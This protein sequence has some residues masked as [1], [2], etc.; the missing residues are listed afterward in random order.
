MN[1]ICI[2]GRLT[3]DPVLRYT[4]DNRPVASYRVAVNRTYARDGQP[5]ADFFQ[6]SSFGKAA[7]FIDRYFIKGMMIAVTGEL[8]IDEYTTKDGDKRIQPTIYASTQDF[9]GDKRQSDQK[10]AEPK[11]TPK[12][13]QPKQE[14]LDEFIP[15]SETDTDLPF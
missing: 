14:S 4:Q 6:V 13:R 3:A 7:E 12:P 11:K 8:R 1:M 9:C 5:D 10:T 15:L 2:T